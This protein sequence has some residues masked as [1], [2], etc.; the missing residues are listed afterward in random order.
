MAKHTYMLIRPRSAPTATRPKGTCNTLLRRR[1]NTPYRGWDG[2]KTKI[3]NKNKTKINTNLT[4]TK[5]KR[6]DNIFHI[7]VDINNAKTKIN[8]TIDKTKTKNQVLGGC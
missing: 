3:K 2:I 7:F 4:K 5:T 8:N 6:K 1:P